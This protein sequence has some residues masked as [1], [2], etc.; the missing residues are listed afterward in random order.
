MPSHS[1]DGNPVQHDI[2]GALLGHQSLIYLV[3][4]EEE[5]ALSAIAAAVAATLP[6]GTPVHRWS[7]ATGI[8]EAGGGAV[9]NTRDPGAALARARAAVAPAVHVFL[10]LHS[11]LTRPEV[12]RGLRDFYHG[13]TH[14]DRF[15]IVVAPVYT[16]PVE[17]RKEMA[18]IDMPPPTLDAIARV[19]DEL[20][21]DL[22]GDRRVDEAGRARAHDI[23]QALQG[24]TLHEARH[25]ALKVLS[26]RPLDDAALRV[27]QDEKGRLIR[28]EGVLEFVPHGVR[29]D[30]VGGLENLKDWLRKRRE[31]FFAKDEERLKDLVPRG[32]LMMGVSGCGKSLSVK[33]I[34]DYWHLP[35]FRLDMNEVFAGTAG[36][37]EESFRRA[38]TSAEAFAPCVLWIDEIEGGITGY[39]SQHSGA[40]W[41]IF[42]TFLT[43]MQEKRA[44]VFV[45]ATANRIDLLPAEILR[46]GRFDQIFFLDLPSEDERADIFR[47]HIASRGNDLS[48][49]DCSILARGTKGWNGAEIEQCVVSAM[50][51]AYAAGRKLEKDDVYA[52]LSNIVPLS[53]TMSE[54]IKAIRSWAHDRALKAGK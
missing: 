34:S 51:E 23:A 28:K 11:Y 31:L 12:V 9:D 35:L 47:V 33:A 17:L 13:A 39:G 46:K 27:I 19:V 10:D 38:L 40:T 6:E 53:T 49:F 42:S 45:A 43:W 54:Q 22:I 37:P 26:E 32:L 18:V 2:R 24:L 3:S 52:Q 15:L 5:R 8:I 30:D 41:R 1:G 14:E 36:S 25:V 4:A 44:A 20:L 21:G 29:L 50:V 16:L 48:L 7:A